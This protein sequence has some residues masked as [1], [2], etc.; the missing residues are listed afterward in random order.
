M[1]LRIKCTCSWF[2]LFRCL[3]LIK[4][5]KF[6]RKILFI[7]IAYY[8]L[9]RS[10]IEYYCMSIILKYTISPNLIYID[11]Y[12]YIQ[13]Y[14]LLDLLFWKNKCFHYKFYLS[15]K[16]MKLFYSIHS[17]HNSIELLNSRTCSFRSCLDI[18]IDWHMLSMLNLMKLSIAKMMY[19]RC[20][21]QLV[22]LKK[23]KCI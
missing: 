8:T 23:K 10:K 2:S 17:E 19:K 7:L 18:D 9:N 4:Y 13:G 5:L 15:N 21:I 20:H 22:R 3:K 11:K 14:K 1:T 6:Q 16:L 12:S